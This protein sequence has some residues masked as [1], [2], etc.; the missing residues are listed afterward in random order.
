[1]FWSVGAAGA[2][3]DPREIEVISYLFARSSFPVWRQPMSVR[4]YQGIRRVAGAMGS[5]RSCRCC[6]HRSTFL[7]CWFQPSSLVF[8]ILTCVYLRDAVGDAH[9]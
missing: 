9:H 7:S 2:A 6:D 1:M 3:S 8:T 5:P 4:R